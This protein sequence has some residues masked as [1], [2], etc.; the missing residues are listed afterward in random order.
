MAPP[1]WAQAESARDTRQACA[2][3]VDL[4][5]CTYGLLFKFLQLDLRILVY[6]SVLKET[7]NV[8]INFN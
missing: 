8:T 4:H 3:Y 6:L 7:D 1:C 2:S 5:P